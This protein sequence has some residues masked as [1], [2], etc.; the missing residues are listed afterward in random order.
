MMNAA[1]F[2]PSSLERSIPF[3]A[4]LLRGIEII[5]VPATLFLFAR[6]LRAATG[7]LYRLKKFDYT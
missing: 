2:D 6:R 1:H 4:A 3:A 7:F 5:P